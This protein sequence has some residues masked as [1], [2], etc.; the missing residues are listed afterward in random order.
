MIAKPQFER[1]LVARPGQR[2]LDWLKMM[3]QPAKIRPLIPIREVGKLWKVTE[4]HVLKVCRS[5]KIPV[6]F[7]PV[8]GH[9][10]SFSGLKSFARA[11]MKYYKRKGLD[12][13]SLLRFY[14]SQIEGVRWKNPLPYSERLDREIN[15]IAQL[16]LQ[17]RTMRSCALWEA[18]R[19]AKRIGECIRRERAVSEEFLQC[20]AMVNEL[21]RKA[22]TG[23]WR[24]KPQT[25][26]AE[27][28]A[29]G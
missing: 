17:Q 24:S 22:A 11:R 1:T 26:G 3:F 6:Q 2:A 15:R 23:E 16:P 7:D 10:M 20:D 4:H 27:L 14:L 21:M 5:Y 29:E 13:A 18:F 12:R 28:N 19:D 8:F 9:L 25:L